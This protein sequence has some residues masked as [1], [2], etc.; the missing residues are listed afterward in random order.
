MSSIKID[1]PLDR[2]GR[3]LCAAGL[4]YDRVVGEFI[5]PHGLLQVEGWFTADELEKLAEAMREEMKADEPVNP[6]TGLPYPKPWPE[7]CGKFRKESAGFDKV[8]GRWIVNVF[9]DQGRLIGQAFDSES[10]TAPAIPPL[11]PPHFGPEGTALGGCS[12]A[13]AQ[14]AFKAVASTGM[15]AAEL[16]DHLRPT[17]PSEIHGTIY[18]KADDELRRRVMDAVINHSHNDGKVSSEIRLTVPGYV[19]HAMLRRLADAAAETFSPA[20]GGVTELFDSGPQRPHE[21]LIWALF[22]CEARR[23][24]AER[25]QGS[26]STAQADQIA[27]L[28]LGLWRAR[29]PEE[30]T[31]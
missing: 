6:A 25:R 14:E 22:F 31:K 27:D 12:V 17:G 19:D 9:D 23:E 8:T 11:E 28:F 30:E 3:G 10:A 2:F 7:E 1:G 26:A 4:G 24:V 20:E 18:W 5:S 21:S 29:W 15:S 13:D 16:A